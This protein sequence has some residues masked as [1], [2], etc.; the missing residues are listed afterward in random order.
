ME[1]LVCIRGISLHRLLPVTRLLQLAHASLR[2][3]GELTVRIRLQ[4]VL[5]GLQGVRHVVRFPI[6]V[7][8]RCMR[9]P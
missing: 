9:S 3:R 7:A 6:A 2:L 8:D 5:I 4:E 1:L